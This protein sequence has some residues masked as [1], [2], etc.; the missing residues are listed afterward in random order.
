MVLGMAERISL[1]PLVELERKPG[2]EKIESPR[3][4]FLLG[5]RHAQLVLL[6]RSL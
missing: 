1:S 4:I 2:R 5:N 6:S 3:P